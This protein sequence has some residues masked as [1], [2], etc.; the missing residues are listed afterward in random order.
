MGK[1]LGDIRQYKQSY[2]I[3]NYLKNLKNFHSKDFPEQKVYFYIAR[4]YVMNDENIKAGNYF[5]KIYEKFPNTHDSEYAMHRHALTF[6]YAG[7]YKKAIYI[8]D[9]TAK[10][11]YKKKINIINIFLSG[12]PTF[13]IKITIQT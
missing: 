6:H 8:I 11:K 10:K 4:Y 2:N 12:T 3:M 7:D 9:K 13:M 1:F 5:K